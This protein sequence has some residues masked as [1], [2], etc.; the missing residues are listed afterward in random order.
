MPAA[1]SCR[2]TSSVETSG[3]QLPSHI[4]FTRLPSRLPERLRDKLSPTM[5]L[6][7]SLGEAARVGSVGKS[8]SKRSRGCKIARESWRELERWGPSRR[9]RF[10]WRGGSIGKNAEML[11]CLARVECRARSTGG[12]RQTKGGGRYRKNRR[13]TAAVC[14][15]VPHRALTALRRVASLKSRLAP[16][17]PTGG[18]AD[19]PS[20]PATAAIG[21]PIVLSENFP[22]YIVR[23]HEPNP[24]GIRAVPSRGEENGIRRTK[25][26]REKPRKRGGTIADGS[27]GIFRILFDRRIRSPSAANRTRGNLKIRGYVYGARS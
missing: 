15:T 3:V 23:F 8:S 5:S 16:T 10:T 27:R 14:V 21:T 25:E 4:F 17:C 24:H 20:L 22:R 1:R 19:W 2:K 11:F 7:L 18:N 6:V 12:D 9:N 13:G 26:G